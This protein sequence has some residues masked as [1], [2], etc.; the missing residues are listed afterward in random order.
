MGSESDEEDPALTPGFD[1][2]C[3]TADQQE[4]DVTLT[5]DQGRKESFHYEPGVIRKMK[6]SGKY[7]LNTDVFESKSRPVSVASLHELSELEDENPAASAAKA[8]DTSDKEEKF[9]SIHKPVLFLK[10]CPS[11]A[12]FL[13]KKLHPDPDTAYLSML[14]SIIS[15]IN[16]TKLHERVCPECGFDHH[17][18]ELCLLDSPGPFGD[19]E[20]E[21]HCNPVFNTAPI[22][23]TTTNVDQKG[24]K[25]KKKKRRKVFKFG[26]SDQ[27]SSDSGWIRDLH[28][29]GILSTLNNQNCKTGKIKLEF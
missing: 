10:S 16:E 7:M 21:V 4:D 1:T 15:D 18:T 19:D 23:K 8:S 24:G 3:F 9:N 26:D 11:P 25:K 13:H 14:Q 20:T 22:S 29:I 28:K 27:H 17:E 12:T 5:R 6:K 2:L